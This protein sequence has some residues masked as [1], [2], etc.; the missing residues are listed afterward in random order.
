MKISIG[1]AAAPSSFR[2]ST[3]TFVGSG[4][5]GARARIAAVDMVR[6]RKVNG[7][8]FTFGHGGGFATAASSIH[9]PARAASLLYR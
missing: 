5:A 6:T 4:S 2:Q 1:S 8:I 7:A 3:K 9:A